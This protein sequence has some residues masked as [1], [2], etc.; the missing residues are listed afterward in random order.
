MQ[1]ET[2]GVGFYQ[3]AALFK[4]QVTMF[5]RRKI[6]EKEENIQKRRI[7]CTN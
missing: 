2:I 4:L 3:H 7:L 6:R 1:R 5:Y